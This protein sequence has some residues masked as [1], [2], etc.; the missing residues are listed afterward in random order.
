M[1]RYQF[2]NSETAPADSKTLT[3]NLFSETFCLIY[4]LVLSMILYY[5]FNDKKWDTM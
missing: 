4:D 3:A 5:S 1:H 2:C